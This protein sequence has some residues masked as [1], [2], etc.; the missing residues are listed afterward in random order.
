[1]M[2]AVKTW[3]S[4]NKYSYMNTTLA[5]TITSKGKEKT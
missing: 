2:S 4:N 1:M 3:K 5:Y